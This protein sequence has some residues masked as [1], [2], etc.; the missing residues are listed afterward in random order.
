MNKP[1]IRVIDGHSF[2]FDNSWDIHDLTIPELRLMIS[3]KRGSIKW[4]NA[5]IAFLEE[6]IARYE[7]VI[8]D[9]QPRYKGEVVE[10]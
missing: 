10:V 3:A 7:K 2:E 8:A 9:K 5:K 4:E 1:E 6:E